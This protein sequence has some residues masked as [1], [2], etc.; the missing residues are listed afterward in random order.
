MGEIEGLDLRLDVVGEHLGGQPVDLEALDDAP[1]ASLEFNV[2][3]I[4]DLVEGL[5]S[6]TSKRTT[7]WP[8]IV[9][10]SGSCTGTGITVLPARCA[11]A[12]T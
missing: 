8:R 2:D 3:D 5:G 11:A 1:S 4:G 6:T 7:G 12:A 10:N 9:L